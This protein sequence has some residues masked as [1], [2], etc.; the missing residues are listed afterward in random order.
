[1]NNHLN[2]PTDEISVTSDQMKHRVDALKTVDPTP[3][4]NTSLQR[5]SESSMA[6][7]NYSANIRTVESEQTILPRSQNKETSNDHTH[8]LTQS[9]D[10]LVSKLAWATKELSDTSSVDYSTQLCVLIKEGVDAL[11]SVR[12]F[13]H[14]N[15]V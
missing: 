9:E 14:S 8:V 7:N 15:E 13:A 11:K 1:M 3:T 5:V 6:P 2:F 4:H 10:A 12:E